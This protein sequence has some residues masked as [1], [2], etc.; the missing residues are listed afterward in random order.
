MRTIAA[1]PPWSQD[2]STQGE[3]R[4]HTVPS[5]SGAWCFVVSEVLDRCYSGHATLGTCALSDSQRLSASQ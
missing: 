2:Q 3:S 4:R 5:K 1:Q